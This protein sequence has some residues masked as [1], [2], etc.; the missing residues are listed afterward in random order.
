VSLN[1]ERGL[2][3]GR[4]D[5]IVYSIFT[6]GVPGS[7]VGSVVRVPR[8]ADWA[9]PGSSCGAHLTAVGAIADVVA[10]IIH[11]GDNPIALCEFSTA[12]S[13]SPW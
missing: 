13:W 9:D 8:V 11:C 3:G 12:A 7:L 10:G 1:P 5:L 6:C 4:I 2:A